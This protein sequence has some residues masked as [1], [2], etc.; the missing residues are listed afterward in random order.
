MIRAMAPVARRK[1]QTSNI[2]WSV[3]PFAI[4]GISAGLIGFLLYQES[5]EFNLPLLMSGALILLLTIM[6]RTF[7]ALGK[8]T[9]W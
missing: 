4:V 9:L 1:R 6:F 8:Q 7:A 2:A 3:M 5:T